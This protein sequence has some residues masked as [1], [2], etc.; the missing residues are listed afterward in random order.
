MSLAL[1]F[2]EVII[3]DDGSLMIDSLNKVIDASCKLVVEYF[4]LLIKV[5]QLFNILEA[6][7]K[8]ECEMQRAI[9]KIF[10]IRI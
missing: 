7:V 9:L 4:E 3:N 10:F 8:M 6:F 1:S 5:V 2:T